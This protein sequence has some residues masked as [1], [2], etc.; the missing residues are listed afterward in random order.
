MFKF[1]SILGDITFLPI[2]IC[3]IFLRVPNIRILYRS[4]NSQKMFMKNVEF[5]TNKVTGVNE[6][7]T[8]ETLGG[9]RVVYANV[10]EI[11]AIFKIW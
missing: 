11:E 3:M 2:K 9:S 1:I 5:E 7:I 6:S 4:G 10:S 8:C